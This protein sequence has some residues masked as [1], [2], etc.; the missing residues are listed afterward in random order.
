[1]RG[2]QSLKTTDTT[3]IPKTASTILADYESSIKNLIEGLEKSIQAKNATKTTIVTGKLLS[4]EEF[5]TNLLQTL[6]R[7]LAFIEFLREQ[8]VL[9]KTATELGTNV[10]FSYPD[11][12]NLD[13]TAV[14]GEEPSQLS[15]RRYPDFY[16]Y[17]P[18][19]LYRSNATD[20]PTTDPVAKELL[21]LEIRIIGDFLEL[22]PPPPILDS[23]LVKVA[24]GN[25]VAEL[26]TLRAQMES[27]LHRIEV[28]EKVS[29]NPQ[30][31]QQDLADK[32]RTFDKMIDDVM[33]K[34]F[35]PENSTT[36]FTVETED[37][38]LLLKAYNA[39]LALSQTSFYFPSDDGSSI[40]TAKLITSS[41]YQITPKKIIGT[42]KLIHKQ[43]NEGRIK[44]DESSHQKNQL[45]NLLKNNFGGNNT[46]SLIDS[47]EKLNINFHNLIKTIYLERQKKES[48]NAKT[49]KS[50]LNQLFKGL[51]ENIEKA[52]GIISESIQNTS[53]KT[54]G[55]RI[56]QSKDSV[57]RQK[58]VA[59]EFIRSE[60]NTKLQQ[61]ISEM[62]AYL[63][64]TD[65]GILN[66]GPFH[67]IKFYDLVKSL[68]TAFD[69]FA[70]EVCETHYNKD[71]A[72]KD[73]TIVALRGVQA[74]F[75]KQA[76][77]R[78][79]GNS[80]DGK[81]QMDTLKENMAAMNNFQPINI[82]SS[83]T[84]AASSSTAD[85]TI[86]ST[87]TTTTSVGAG[88]SMF[89]ASDSTELRKNSDNDEL[90]GIN[91][92]PSSLN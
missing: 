37:Q 65:D 88:Y 89:P 68:D 5:K 79:S 26:L 92:P 60:C 7:R 90:Q 46:E 76:V 28:N 73:S 36:T 71:N 11:N 39:L 38:T 20:I 86:T 14:H 16:T 47:L 61:A 31:T 22:S 84:D 54:A 78:L 43:I 15:Q 18:Q 33:R 56:F 67:I 75:L 49:L 70:Q 45:K 21:E 8:K 59:D 9:E 91:L 32:I 17:L 41:N 64:H 35:E 62:Q 72:E 48:N 42:L 30:Q 24:G 44:L 55:F 19:A 34:I 23:V 50:E 4:A 40:E 69:A 1:M 51:I 77:V 58:A 25:P 29:I 87:T 74:G 82:S 10:V 83:Q 3:N 6:N 13:F 52:S 63:Q 12:K 2:Q 57:E 66:Y 80:Q 53:K 81:T 27:K 85:S